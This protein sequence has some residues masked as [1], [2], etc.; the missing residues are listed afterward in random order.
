VKLGTCIGRDILTHCVLADDKE[1]G[2]GIVLLSESERV[3]FVTAKT[4]KI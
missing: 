2:E 1:M 4:W 3:S